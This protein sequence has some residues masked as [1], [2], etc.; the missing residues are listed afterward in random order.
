MDVSLIRLYFSNSFKIFLGPTNFFI[1]ISLQNTILFYTTFK[2]LKNIPSLVYLLF[3][4]LH[5]I[6]TLSTS[7]IV[8]IKIYRLS[9]IVIVMFLYHA[10]FLT[11]IVLLFYIFYPHWI[12]IIYITLDIYL[13]RLK[14][15]CFQTGF[16]FIFEDCIKIH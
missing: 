10:L 9:T 14:P 6:T 13:P 5:I 11:C 8:S 12:F 2:F 3:V 1:L 16:L 4:F 7:V 15:F